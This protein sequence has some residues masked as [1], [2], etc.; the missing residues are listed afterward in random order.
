MKHT[1]TQLIAIGSIFILLSAC[2]STP[3]QVVST[4]TD[5]AAVEITNAVEPTVTST[6]IS[7]ILTTTAEIACPKIN[8]GFQFNL[9]IESSEFESAIQN[10]LDEGGNPD[11]IE[12][13]ASA[14][15][16]QSF[17]TLS[18]PGG[19]LLRVKNGN[20]AIPDMRC[21]RVLSKKHPGWI[22]ALT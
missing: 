1:G 8:P 21:W 7:P 15:E 16:I 6:Q 4:Q 2:T 17:F 18:L 12:A 5:T 10:Y 20:T 13:V 11:E 14:S 19:I 3:V 9:P 22:S